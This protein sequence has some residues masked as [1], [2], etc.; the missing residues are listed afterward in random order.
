MPEMGASLE[1]PFLQR[2]IERTDIYV[3][4]FGHYA[5]KGTQRFVVDIRKVLVDFTNHP[6]LAPIQ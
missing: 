3:V 4:A 6:P 1:H 2:I 5:Q